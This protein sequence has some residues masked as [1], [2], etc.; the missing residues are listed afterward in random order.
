[1]NLRRTSGDCRECRAGTGGQGAFDHDRC[2]LVH[3]HD[4]T[5]LL[6]LHMQKSES[7]ARLSISAHGDSRRTEELVLPA[8]PARQASAQKCRSRALF[9]VSHCTLGTWAQNPTMQQDSALSDAMV[10]RLDESAKGWACDLSLA[11]PGRGDR[12]GRWRPQSPPQPVSQHLQRS[13]HTGLFGFERGRYHRQ[14]QCDDGLLRGM[15]PWPRPPAAVRA[16]SVY[17]LPLLERAHANLAPVPGTSGMRLSRL[18]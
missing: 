17:T 2:A 8:T 6:L 12:E 13:Q 4:T 9:V 11:D 10:L 16:A 14:P 3:R 5:V 7:N 1:M 15:T 18:V